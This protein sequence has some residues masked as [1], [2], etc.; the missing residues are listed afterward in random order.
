MD[1]FGQNFFQ[2]DLYTGH[3]VGS[4]NFNF[5]IYL[6]VA[7]WVHYFR[8][9]KFFFNF[10]QFFQDIFS[11]RLIRGSTYTRVYAVILLELVW[12]LD[13]FYG[14]GRYVKNRMNIKFFKTLGLKNI[15]LY[16]LVRRS[17]WQSPIIKVG[18]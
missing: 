16:N 10:G 6:F 4:Q 3:K 18:N 14:E 9:I 17:Q 15:S 8:R 1:N 11:I 12:R 2:F 5:F 13:N 7:W